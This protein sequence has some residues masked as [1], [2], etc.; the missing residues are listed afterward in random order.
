MKPWVLALTGPTAVGKTAMAVALGKHFGVPILSADSRQF[1]REMRIGTAV[2]TQ[3][4]Q[5]RARHFFVHHLS[6][7]DSYDAGVYREEATALLSVLHQKH[8]LS[9]LCG[10]SGLYIDAVLKGFHQFPEVDEEIRNR[11][12][13]ALEQKGLA[14]LQSELKTRDPVYYER[15][16][17]QNPH[18]LIRALSVC[19]AGTQPYSSYLSGELPAR[20]FDV[21]Y[22]QLEAPRDELYRRIEARV[23]RMMVEGLLEEARE[24]YPH[25][26]L[27]ALQT[28][29]YQELF[30]HMSGRYSLDQAVEE[31]KKN[32]RRYAKRQL[33]WLRQTSPRQ[34]LP[35]DTDPH[36]LIQLVECLVP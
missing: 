27:K 29:G 35:F 17:I 15:V 14:F 19:E 7:Q 20:P 6:I 3:D 25:R 10:G 23:D 26:E 33:T 1:Y 18:R 24:L 11:W 2:P 28:V 21:C 34:V 5:E 36:K 32:T 8:R 13:L 30:A 12:I 22:L 16:D 9:I 4:E 31:I